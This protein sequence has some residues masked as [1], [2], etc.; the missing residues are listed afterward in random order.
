[1]TPMAEEAIKKR[2][3]KKKNQRKSC[4]YLS[5]QSLRGVDCICYAILDGGV[6]TFIRFK[7]HTF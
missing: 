7:L 4:C 1:M 5:A 6:H 3:M 2:N